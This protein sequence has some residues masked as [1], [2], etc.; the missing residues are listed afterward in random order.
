M[1]ITE[2]KV[3]LFR[4]NYVGYHDEMDAKGT[5]LYFKLL[6][7]L[8]I[9][10]V[11]VGVIIGIFGM[12]LGNIGMFV[13]SILGTLI[14]E[15]LMIVLL[16]VLFD[17]IKYGK[18]RR[19][20]KIVGPIIVGVSAFLLIGIFLSR[21]VPFPIVL[22]VGILLV[23][24][25]IGIGLIIAGS[26][27]LKKQ[28][29]NCTLPV[30]AVCS[31]YETLTPHLSILDAPNAT[32]AQN[33]VFATAEVQRPIWEF[34]YNGT[35][36]H[37]TPEHYEGKL[38]I[39]KDKQYKIYVNPENPQEIYCDENDNAGFLLRMGKFWLIFCTIVFALT[40]GV[41]LLLMRTFA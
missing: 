36:I 17:K 38:K 12:M 14:S 19:E 41:M 20:L 2:R 24:Y 37:A 10:I 40:V 9:L 13:L 1:K 6:F 23:F 35:T 33:Q 28:R 29:K 3:N 30:W 11:P 15:F 21:F 7:A 39:I 25:A 5:P 27:Q 34:D 4:G 8:A 22:G 16:L 18:V 26:N 31:G 32:Y